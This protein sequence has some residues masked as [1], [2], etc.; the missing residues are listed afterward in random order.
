MRPDAGLPDP[1]GC[2]FPATTGVVDI[3]AFGFATP[4]QPDGTGQFGVN[5][6]DH[7][8]PRTSFLLSFAEGAG[9]FTGGYATGT[10]DPFDYNPN[11]CGACLF[12]AGGHSV[13]FVIDDATQ[14]YLPT[15][16]SLT[17]TAADPSVVNNPPSPS[18]Y[19]G[20]FTNVQLQGFETTN[21]TEIPCT[22][23]VESLTFE[24]NVTWQ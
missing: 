19:I 2:L 12:L 16:G 24:F 11:N 20:T 1:Q 6:E 8:P 5:Y 22:V 17:L 10:F 3:P 14:I 18:N 21:N 15:A 9:V 13:D 4:L 23:T 7:G